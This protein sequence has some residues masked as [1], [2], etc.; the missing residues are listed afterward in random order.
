[1]VFSG[2]AADGRPTLWLIRMKNQRVG[3]EQLI[4]PRRRGMAYTAELNIDKTR[5]RAAQ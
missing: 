3:D 2:C 1:M 5:S 4:K